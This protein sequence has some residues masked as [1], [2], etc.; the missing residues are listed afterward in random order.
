MIRKILT[1]IE[2]E[3]I[4]TCDKDFNILT[5]KAIAFDKKIIEISSLNKLCKKYK[6]A[7]VIKK[8]KNSV[9]MPGLINSHTHLEF[10]SNTTS[11]KYGNF[12]SWLYSVLENRQYVINKTT[13]DTI[14]R[15]LNY[16]MET[17]TTTIGGN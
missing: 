12:L 4:V 9:V 6:N 17:G 8:D 7:R 16:M 15:Q 10:S 1:I 14:N 3:F 2:S 11:F 13:K 5:N